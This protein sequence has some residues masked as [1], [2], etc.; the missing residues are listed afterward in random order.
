M[1]LI[2]MIAGLILSFSGILILISSLTRYFSGVEIMLN[3]HET[4]ILSVNQPL[5]PVI[6]VT[7][8]DVHLAKGKKQLQRGIFISIICFVTGFGLLMTA[9][10]LTV[11]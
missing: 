1:I 9:T 3:A 2:E 4:Y 10:I 11:M 6:A 8:A 7:G 5:K